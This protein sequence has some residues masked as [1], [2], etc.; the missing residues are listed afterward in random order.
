MRVDV[1]LLKIGGQHIL[2]FV[3]EKGQCIPV[4]INDVAPGVGDDNG[5]PRLFKKRPVF[6]LAFAQGML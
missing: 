1:Q 6:F 2:L 4:G 5:V 3:S